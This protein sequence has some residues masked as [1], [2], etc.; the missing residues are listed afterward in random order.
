MFTGIIITSLFSLINNPVGSY[1]GDI[2][3][4]MISTQKIYVDIQEN[5]NG[6]I[7]LKGP[8]TQEELF[9]YDKKLDK[10]II[11]KKITKL[12]AKYRCKLLSINYNTID[13]TPNVIVKL[14]LPIIGDT[15]FKMHKL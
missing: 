15:I 13:N 9:Y 6:K 11:G 10:P 8:I 5:L 2:K 12:L 1:Y 4:P 7:Y 3:I 14:N